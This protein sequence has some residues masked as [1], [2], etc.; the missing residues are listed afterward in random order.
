MRHVL[1]SRL[2]PGLLL[3]M[4]AAPAAFAQTSAPAQPVAA[5]GSADKPVIAAGTVPDEATRAS[6]N[7][8]A[9]SAWS[10]GSRSAR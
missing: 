10:T 5:A 8:T 2:L 3:A 9:P 4:L 7:S 6:T 1:S